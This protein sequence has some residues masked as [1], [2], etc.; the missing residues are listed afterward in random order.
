[1]PLLVCPCSDFTQKCGTGGAALAWFGHSHLKVCS[2]A[3]PK[4]CAVCVDDD[5][6]HALHSRWAPDWTVSGQSA[7]KNFLNPRGMVGLKGGTQTLNMLFTHFSNLG[8]RKHCSCKFTTNFNEF[9]IFLSVEYAFC[10]F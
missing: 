2:N 4:M 3:K 10:P 1:M 9:A 6:S 7:K 5:I 8:W